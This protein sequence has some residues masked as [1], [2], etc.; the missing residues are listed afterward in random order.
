MDKFEESLRV[1]MATSY[2]NCHLNKSADISDRSFVN[3]L[4]IQLATLLTWISLIQSQR[5]I[6]LET[7]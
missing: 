4:L 6:G 2:L 7:G 1:I 3:F 5:W